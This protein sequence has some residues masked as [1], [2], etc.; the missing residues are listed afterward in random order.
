MNATTVKKLKH[1]PTQELGHNYLIVD[2]SSIN[3][4]EK[5]G[6]KQLVSS[7]APNLVLRGRTFFTKKI[8]LEFTERRQQ[9]I[10]VLSNCTDAATTIEALTQK[11][12]YR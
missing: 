3:T 10:D 9:L 5:P 2:V 4:V 8:E 7:L 12:I 6:F 1:D 11:I